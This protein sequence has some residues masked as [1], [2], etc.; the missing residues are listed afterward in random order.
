MWF[1]GFVCFFF[2]SCYATLKAFDVW[3][4]S[5]ASYWHNLLIPSTFHRIYLNG[6]LG[7]H[8]PV[9]VSAGMTLAQK[10]GTYHLFM[11]NASE[12]E[13]MALFA[14]LSSL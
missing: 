8:H 1:K 5:F 6:T 10:L 12:T 11:G 13:I 4:C 7:S 9:L 2:F 14:C 3:F